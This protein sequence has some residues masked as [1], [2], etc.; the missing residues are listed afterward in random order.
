MT[1]DGEP[2]RRYSET[3]SEDAFAELVRRQLELVY[4]AALRQVNGDAPLAQDVARLVFAD[5]TRKAASL[6]DR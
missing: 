1:S 2:L 4:S 6:V 3:N 5:L